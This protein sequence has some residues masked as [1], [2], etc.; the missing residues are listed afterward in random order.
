MEI[1]NNLFKAKLSRRQFCK[2]CLLSGAGLLASP[3]LFQLTKKSYAAQEK[4]ALFYEKKSA[5]TIQCG[6]CPRRCVLKNGMLGFCRARRP[7]GGMHYT[8]VYANP[9]AVHIDPIEKKPL[10]HFLPATQAF[11]I[12]TAGCNFRCKYCQNWQISQVSPEETFNEDMPPAAVVNAAIRY[13][14][15]TIAYTYTEPSIFYEYML[16]TAKIAKSKGLRNMYH[17][18]GSLN[19]KPLEELCLY[20]DGADIDLKAFNQKYYSEVCEGYL[21]TVL[22]TLKTLKKNRVWVEITNLVVPTL[23]DDPAQIKEM[24]VW[25]KDNLGPDVPVHFARFHP[26][27]KL[28]TLYPTPVQTLEKARDLAVGVGLN[29]VYIGNVPG[30][31]YENTYCPSCKQSLIERYGFSITRYNITP[32]KHCPYCGEEILIIGEPHVSNL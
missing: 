4:E 21:D 14:C 8:L 11:S 20:L 19:Q 22:N 30:H 10:F 32:D 2:I 5:D 28:N 15:P 24:V 27:Y 9:T 25:I 16:D 26:M 1:I 13:N 18:N 7:R 6:L 12:A 17:S 29:Y 31:P 23:N 3:L